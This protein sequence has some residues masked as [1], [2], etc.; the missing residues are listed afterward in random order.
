MAKNDIFTASGRIV[1]VLPNTLFRVELD[2]GK[3]LLGHLA[4]KLRINNINVLI[5]DSV[6]VE[7]SSYDVTKCRISR[8]HK[9]QS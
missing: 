8:R 3:I 5:G 6:D 9:R 4:G 1:E 7:I 2:N